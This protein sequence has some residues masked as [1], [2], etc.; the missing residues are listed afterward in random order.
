LTPTLKLW[1]EILFVRDK[2]ANESGDDIRVEFTLE[3]IGVADE[4]GDLH[5]L[6]L[7]EAAQQ[8]EDVVEDGDFASHLGPLDVAHLFDRAVI[9]LDAPMPI[10]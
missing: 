3:L 5:L 2:G 6:Q 7:D 1:I 4:G 9:L 10:M 8:G